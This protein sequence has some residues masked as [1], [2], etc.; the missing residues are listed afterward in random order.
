VRGKTT[1]QGYDA[2]HGGKRL[3]GPDSSLRLS[4]QLA[5]A[6]DAKRL[7][8][9]RPPAD[10]A[11]TA[12]R[13]PSEVHLSR[14]VAQFRGSVSQLTP[15]K[16]CLPH[17]LTQ[18]SCRARPAMPGERYVGTDNARS[19][20]GPYIIGGQNEPPQA[21]IGVTRLPL[22]AG[23]TISLAALLAIFDALL[24]DLRRLLP[25]LCSGHSSN[26]SRHRWFIPLRLFALCTAR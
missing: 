11:A 5:P 1:S 2:R 14:A 9:S 10:L 23:P 13:P 26:L 7:R 21:T 17:R 6:A 8:A 25:T 24:T 3:A 16:R 18:E 22:M 20:A 12:T 4:G 15:A 19:A